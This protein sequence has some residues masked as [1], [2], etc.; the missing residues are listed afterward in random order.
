MTA[1][2]IGAG[3]STS[4]VSSDLPVV[5]DSANRPYI[6]GSSFKGV[7]RSYIESIMRSIQGLIEILPVT[8][9]MGRLSVLNQ[10]RDERPP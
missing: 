8:Q 6:P 10:N 3:R 4:P 5:R 7:L 2:R 1:I 9:P